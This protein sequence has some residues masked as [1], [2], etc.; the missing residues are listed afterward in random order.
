MR[1]KIHSQPRC[2]K[3]LSILESTA[4]LVIGTVM[5]SYVVPNCIERINRAK[6][7]KT[8]NEMTSIAQA[9]IDF[10]ISQYPRAWPTDIS[11]LAPKHMF[12]GVTLNPWGRRYGPLVF[13]NNLV[14][15][16]TTIPPGIV[17]LDPV[18]VMVKM[19]AGPNNDDLVS[20]AQSVP[21]EGIG[22]LQYE[23]K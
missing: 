6:Y 11:Q 14:I 7:E 22:R 19:G 17:P 13:Q 3:G 23:K 10:Y 5:L 2:H 9:S 16:T 18:G 12:Q 8:V 15:M 4:V 21:N 20:I 1:L